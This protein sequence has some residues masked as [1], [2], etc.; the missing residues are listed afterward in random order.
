M[1]RTGRAI[2]IV[3]L[4]IRLI[5]WK[6]E[7]SLIDSPLAFQNHASVNKYTLDQGRVQNVPNFIAVD[8]DVARLRIGHDIVVVIAKNTIHIRAPQKES[9]IGEYPAMA[10]G[11]FVGILS[12][13]S[14]VNETI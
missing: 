11:H 5:R 3:T 9:T 1:V 7:K 14:Q 2:V 13:D 4:G 12:E 8:H 6:M 10:I